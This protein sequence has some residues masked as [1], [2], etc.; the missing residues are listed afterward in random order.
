[1]QEQEAEPSSFHG[2]PTSPVPPMGAHPSAQ[3]LRGACTSP[4]CVQLLHAAMPTC[5][6]ELQ[7]SSVKRCTPCEDSFK[8]AKGFCSASHK[9][10]RLSMP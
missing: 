2:G 3:E 4:W 7:L 5:P 9:C 6:S 8:K 10:S 1:M